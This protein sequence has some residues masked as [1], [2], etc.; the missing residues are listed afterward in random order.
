MNLFYIALGGILGAITRYEC[1]IRLFQKNNF[2]YTTLFINVLG[3]FLLGIFY[4]L[5]S[6][7]SYF[8]FFIATGFFGAFTT[9]STFSVE[10]MQFILNRRWKYLFLYIILTIAGTII[11]LSF[12]IQLTYFFFR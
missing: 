7:D 3:S 10:A 2:P 6:H 12:A 9:F 4:A 11:S 1:S 8:Y 5:L